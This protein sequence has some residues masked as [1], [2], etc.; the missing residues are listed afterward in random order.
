M[1]CESP[2]AVA[3]RRQPRGLPPGDAVQNEVRGDDV[4]SEARD[5]S[6][7]LGMSP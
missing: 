1:F 7:S 5:A 4:P 3:P 2:L 6:L